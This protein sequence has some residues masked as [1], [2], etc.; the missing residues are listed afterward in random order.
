[1]EQDEVWNDNDYDSLKDQ[2]ILDKYNKIMDEVIV[3]QK[4]IW[5][6]YIFGDTNL[7]FALPFNISWW[8]RMWC[9]VFFGSTFKR[10]N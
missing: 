7:V 1:M 8:R 9:K 5:E 6:W 10:I 4:T 3:S 2:E